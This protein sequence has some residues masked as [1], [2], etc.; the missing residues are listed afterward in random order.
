MGVRNTDSN[1]FYL[2][3]TQA[4]SLFKSTN[5]N[6]FNRN[7]ND[8]PLESSFHRDVAVDNYNVKAASLAK[9][10][11]NLLDKL[12]ELSAGKDSFDKVKTNVAR[13][14]ELIEDSYNGTLTGSALDDAQEEINSLV[15]EIND[16][17]AN[18]KVAGKNLFDGSFNLSLQTGTESGDTFNLDFTN[19]TSSVG[20]PDLVR[21]YL[22]PNGDTGDAFRIMHTDEN[23]IVASSPDN[24]NSQAEGLNDNNGSVYIFDS[25]TGNFL[26]EIVAPNNGV[27]NQQFG[28]A[29]HVQGNYLLVGA[30]GNVNQA[31][32]G[33]TLD[34]D[35]VG[36]AYLYDI[37]TGNL[38]TTFT[39]SSLE[40]DNDVN[41]DIGSHGSMF[42]SAVRIHGDR[43]FI[44]ATR[45]RNG[46]GTQGA[47][48]EFD[49]SGNFIKKYTA[50]AGTT[51]FF[52][53]TFTV[54]DDAVYGSMGWDDNS[55]G[56]VYRFSRATG[57]ITATFQAPV[58]EQGAFFGSSISIFG[59]NIL[60][61]A[62]GNYGPSAAHNPVASYEGGAYLFNKNTGALI[63]DFT[64]STG[65]D[66]GDQFGAS[67]RL[68]G[69]YAV[70]T[71]A[72]DDDAG[73]N[74]GAT[75]VFDS[76][77]G[78]LV[79]KATGV[80]A[81]RLVGS[82][83][84]GSDSAFNS[85]AGIGREYDFLSGISVSDSSLDLRTNQVKAGSIGAFSTTSLNQLS[86]SNN[87]A[88]LGGT[89]GAANISTL[90]NINK[91]YD[92]IIRMDS[93]LNSGVS[94]LQNEYD[95]SF[96]L[97]QTYLNNASFIN[98]LQVQGAN[99]ITAS[100]LLP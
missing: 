40:S 29:L 74:S 18:T 66:G 20:V 88:S 76:Q 60:I 30:D 43:A 15:S 69:N 84:F 2:R 56:E 71:A 48:F 21:E 50:P 17:A 94:R 13:I 11:G 28:K 73:T 12:D 42:G 54:T 97:R 49:L 1:A 45:Q 85:S 4:E 19:S 7:I 78:D 72:G 5:T 65:M 96:Q 57:A 24:N 75:Y 99:P 22:A 8:Q 91:I 14:K 87:I 79:F 92:N 59:D 44:T 47:I 46:D 93:I 37:T 41:P 89:T 3:A 64:P 70:M 53:G 10:S 83:L 82:R 52:G 9:V 32:D 36:G 81:S 98:N 34:K 6:F 31:V 61:G 33:K 25:Q 63:R 58:R 39:H 62:G 27:I 35:Y 23:Y 100:N 68:T 90:D 95:R 51:D 86:V 77:S 26:R 55:R 67:V 38:L 80:V 16:I